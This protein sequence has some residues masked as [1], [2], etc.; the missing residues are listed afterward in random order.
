MHTRF[1]VDLLHPGWGVHNWYDWF[2]DPR[3]PRRLAVFTLGCVAVLV[4]VLA[5]VILPARLRLS[6]TVNALPG[7]RRD[8]EAR[9]NDLT[10]LRANLGGLTQEAKRQVRWADVLTA[11]SQQ[12]P[13]ALKLEVVD[14]T[15]AALP[16]APHPPGGPPPARESVLRI[17]S[18]TPL[19]PGSQPLADVA[20][21]IAG[22]MREP[23]VNERFQVGSWEIKP[24]PAPAQ[25]G[26]RLLDVSIVLTE[27]TR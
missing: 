17:S 23:T 12:I 15:R 6:A 16:G 13:A 1:N 7:L 22:L 20:Q 14:A 11:L 4:I 8:L 18:V 10:V 3:A 9:Q 2:V 19:R 24:G 25:G 26:E 27:R 21:F 5:G